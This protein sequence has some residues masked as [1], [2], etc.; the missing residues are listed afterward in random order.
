M[1]TWRVYNPSEDVN[2]TESMYGFV[3]GCTNL[4]FGHKSAS[5]LGSG[6]THLRDNI[7]DSTTHDG[8]VLLIYTVT[9]SW[10][11]VSLFIERTS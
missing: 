3:Y 1:E 6:I 10:A 8:C 2:L 11:I 4:I 5:C 7:L 9:V